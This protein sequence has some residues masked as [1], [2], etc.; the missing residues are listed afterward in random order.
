[1]TS[2][3]RSQPEGVYQS[4]LLSKSLPSEYL[5]NTGCPNSKADFFIATRLL[6]FIMLPLKTLLSHRHIPPITD[7]I[8]THVLI[9]ITVLFSAICEKVKENCKGTA[10]SSSNN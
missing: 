3:K 1:M 8:V 7:H 4:Q 5:A 2:G 10:E 6:S 9:L